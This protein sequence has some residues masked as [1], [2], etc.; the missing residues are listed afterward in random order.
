MKR[1]LVPVVLLMSFLTGCSTP[2]TQALRSAPL[3]AETG[4][5]E[6]RDVPFVPGEE[7]MG[8]PAALAILLR[9]TGRDV[10]PEQ[11]ARDIDPALPGDDMAV[12]LALVARQQGRL[13]YPL[14]P[15]LEAMLAALNQGYPVLVRQN[16]GLSFW[17]AWHYAV[18]VG[19]DRRSET[20]WLRSGS[21]ER[22]ALSFASFER[23]WARGGHWAA[24]I[25]D[26]R[27]IPES[28]DARMVIRELAMMERAGALADAQAGFNRALLNWPE[29]KTAWL[30]LASTS[31]AL[32]EMDR[33]E[34][35][36]R[37]L[38]RR[39][40][41]YGA[42]LNNL[43]DL[44][45]KTGRPLEALPFAERAVSVLDIPQTRS[46]LQA[47]R[48]A[49]EP[50]KTEALPAQPGDLSPAEARPVAVASP[51]GKG[52]KAGRKHRKAA[53]KA[54]APAAAGKAAAAKGEAVSGE[55]SRGT[56][57]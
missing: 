57:P 1:V 25:I 15:R 48:L 26:P 16:T 23:G 43:A 22:Q 42:G 46:T 34:S 40:P 18:V 28:L 21:L 12:A 7:R 56:T 10:T 36:L 9:H 20:F 24:L 17:P 4:V 52:S 19:A 45:L 32:G 30:G 39:A 37:E 50:I 14:A 49:M 29:Q 38:V 2:Q 33:A 5:V 51:A 54:K 44:L 8:A 27:Q 13:V 35:T 11:V 53:H 6:L 31:Q 3:A 41:Q 55:A 47:A